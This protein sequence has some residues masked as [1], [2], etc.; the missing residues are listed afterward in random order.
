MKK[1]LLTAANL[2]AADNDSGRWLFRGYASVFDSKNDYGFK[3]A[4]GA[5]SDVLSSGEKPA[6][7]FNHDYRD[8]PIGKWLTLSEDEHGLAVEGELSQRVTRAK[9]VHG[10]LLDGTITGMSI[11]IVFDENA[12]YYE[13]DGTGV[14]TKVSAMPEISLC[15]WPADPKARVSEALSADEIDARIDAIKTERDFESFVRD[16]AGLSRRQAARLSRAEEAVI[17]A[18]LQR[19]AAEKKAAEAKA[20]D[21]QKTAALQRLLGAVSK[22]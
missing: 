20:E 1:M 15:T 8:V 12:I 7:F 6:M 13:S 2:E 14:L 9:D 3:I 11:N 10:G 19:D 21:E 16:A 4:P 5:F 22:L 18:K 17:S